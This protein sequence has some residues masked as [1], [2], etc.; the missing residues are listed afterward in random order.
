MDYGIN[1]SF[2][3][4]NTLTPE[5][6]L[7]GNSPYLYG[8]AVKANLRR[9]ARRLPGITQWPNPELGYEVLHL[10]IVSARQHTKI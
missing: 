6:I 5:G 1:R 8:E 7:K 9:G 2:F 3:C 10:S 4:N